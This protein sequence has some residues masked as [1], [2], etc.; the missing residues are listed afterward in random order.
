MQVSL[1]C[2]LFLYVYIKITDGP[3]PQRHPLQSS[4][5]CWEVQ[6]ESGFCGSIFTSLIGFNLND[7]LELKETWRNT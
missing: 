5:T 2:T 1:P 6:A 7:K 4:L 3:R